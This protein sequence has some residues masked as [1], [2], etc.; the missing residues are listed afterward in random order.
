M[1]ERHV[2]RTAPAILLALCVAATAAL[3]GTNRAA[4]ADGAIDLGGPHAAYSQSFDTL[5]SKG[6]SAALPLGWSLK[7][8]GST[9]TADGH[10]RAFTAGSGAGDTYSFGTG[11]SSERAFGALRSD[12]LVP[13][14]GV[15]FTNNTGATIDALAIGYTGEQ[16]RLGAPNRGPDQLHF[17]FSTDTTSL[18]TGT[19]RDYD[20]LDF[21]SPATTGSAGA[22]DG[23]A[24]IN[25]KAISAWIPGLSIPNGQSFWLRW[26]DADIPGADDGLAIDDFSLT[27]FSGPCAETYTPI[28]QIQGVGATAAITGTVTTQ[29]VVV[30]DYEGPS[31]ALRGFYLQDASGDGDPTTSDG[32]FVFN[33]SNADSVKLGEVVRI[34]GKAGENQGQTQ[35][36][37]T[38]ETILKCGTGS[39]AAVDVTLPLSS[40]TQLE[41]LEGMLVRFPQPLYVTEHFQLGRFGQVVLS[42]GGRLAQ[43]TNIVAPGV[44]AQALEAA[45][46]LNRIIVDDASQAQNTD[47]IVFAR[48]GQPLSA[49][50][51]LR[52]GDSA[53]GIVGVMT[54]TWGGDQA[55]PNAYRVRPGNALGG[56]ASF[57]PSNPRP[58][59]APPAA[60]RVRVAGMNL[61]NFFNTFDGLP[62]RVDNCRNGVGSAAADCR[63]ADTQ[64]EFDRQWPKTAAA[65]MGSGADVIGVMELENDGYGPDSSMRFL[66]DQLNAATAPDAYAYVDV[67]TATGQANSLG[68]DAIRVGI[69]YKPAKVTPVGRTAVLNTPAFVTGGDGGAR[70]RPALAQAFEENGTGERFI[71]SVNHLKSKG[72]ACA[73]PDTGDGQGNCASVRTLAANLLAQWLATDPTGTGD[74]DVL[75]VGDFNSYAQEDPITALKNAGYINLIESFNGSGAYS[76]AF[77]GAWGY[78]DHALGSASLVPQ[79]ASVADWHINADEPAVLD[80][81]TDFKTLAQRQSLYAP[82]EFRISDHDPV[83][84][85]LNLA[86]AAPPAAAALPTTGGDA[87]NVWLLLTTVLVLLGL[88]VSALVTR[89]TAA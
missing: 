19:W 28:Y 49:S 36:S 2:L 71:V 61:L 59:G 67:D 63:G 42:S 65:I 23:N 77:N 17:Q 64:A 69:L 40:G 13:L 12:D 45:N 87:S 58:A 6:S 56:A 10:Y 29:G 55:S 80:Y 68:T 14:F 88:G 21:S 44:P 18:A 3:W 39:V 7:E 52:G 79:V 1:N 50:N 51:T 83:L 31:P 82:D 27:P 73:A 9:A 4:Q 57:A 34:T 41:Q 48:G 26:V 74:P 20:A 86:A 15:K 33:G 25:R 72:S 53:E 38:P 62:D 75:L 66:V 60:G 35:I 43:P 24:A 11:S 81:N 76:Y 8:I 30:G 5:A 89:R 37:V 47:P 85:D 78:L 84:V 16:W 46:T 54:F 70:N 22:L 32:I